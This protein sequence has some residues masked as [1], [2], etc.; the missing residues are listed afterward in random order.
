MNFTT[1]VTQKGQATIPVQIRELLGIKKNTKIV[2]EI[3]NNKE[4]SIKPVV[5]FFSLKGSIKTNK[6][7]DVEAMEKAI[8]DAVVL[9]YGKKSN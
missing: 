4:V 6:P 5:D 9:K 8:E 1:T 7:F 2:F 3:K